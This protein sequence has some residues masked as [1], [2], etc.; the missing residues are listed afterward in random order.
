MR[1]LK[2]SKMY[3]RNLRIM[4]TNIQCDTCEN[5]KYFVFCIL[6]NQIVIIEIKRKN[7]YN[8]SPT[9]NQ[10]IQLVSQQF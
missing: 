9:L 1:K 4:T 8:L 3:F 5:E 2:L 7:V 6:Q 10:P